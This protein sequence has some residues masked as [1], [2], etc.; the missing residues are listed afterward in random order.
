MTTAKAIVEAWRLKVTTAAAW[1]LVVLGFARMGFGYRSMLLCLFWVFLGFEPRLHCCCCYSVV[2][3][4]NT[5][6][7]LPIFPFA[8]SLSRT[9]ICSLFSNRTQSRQRK[10][11]NNKNSLQYP[12]T[13]TLS[14]SLSLSLRFANNIYQHLENSFSC[15]LLLLFAIFGFKSELLTCFCFYFCVWFPL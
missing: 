1:R 8:I 4:F 11:E 7:P 13:Q 2:A 12:R 10:I 5:L 9:H 15:I 3:Q 6:T 14:L